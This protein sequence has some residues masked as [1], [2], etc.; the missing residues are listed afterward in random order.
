[1]PPPGIFDLFDCVSQSLIQTH[2]E[3]LL[4]DRTVVSIKV[5][6]RSAMRGVISDHCLPRNAKLDFELHN[7]LGHAAMRRLESDA[8]AHP[9]LWTNLKFSLHYFLLAAFH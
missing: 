4:C 1:M 3:P 2:I 5:S 6:M 9:F 8:I 7:E